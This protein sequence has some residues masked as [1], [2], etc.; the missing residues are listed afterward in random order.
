MVLGQEDPITHVPQREVRTQR[1]PLDDMTRV[2][3]RV[4]AVTR[5]DVH[6][7]A[8]DLFTSELHRRG[9]RAFDPDHTFAAVG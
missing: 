2:L 4:D 8:T 5:D 7:V 6:A 1:E 3:D 9:D